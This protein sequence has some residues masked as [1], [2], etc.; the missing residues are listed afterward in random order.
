MHFL[1]I[2]G[3]IKMIMNRRRSSDGDDALIFHDLNA[4][5]QKRYRALIQ[6]G[7]SERR[8][9]EKFM[10]EF[11]AEES[12]YKMLSKKQLAELLTGHFDRPLPSLTRMNRDDL[13]LICQCLKLDPEIE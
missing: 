5:Q 8:I 1:K 4:E 3:G 7:H 10:K 6:Q 11:Q 9:F 13:T 2:N 12:G